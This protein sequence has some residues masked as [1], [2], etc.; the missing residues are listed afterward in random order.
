MKK[1]IL[2]ALKENQNKLTQLDVNFLMGKIEEKNY[3]KKREELRK[4][5]KKIIY[6]NNLINTLKLNMENLIK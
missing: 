6:D 4:N 3:L 5:V 1:T 2:Q